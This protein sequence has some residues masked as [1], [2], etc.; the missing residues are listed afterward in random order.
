MVLQH[1][2]QRPRRVVV[3]GPALDAD[4]LGHRDL[5]VVDH[6]R[7]PEPVEDRVGE[8]QRQQVLH[9]LL[10]E[11]VVDPEDLLFRK[12]LADRVVDRA[13]RLEVLAD[14]LLEHDAGLLAD[15][16]ELGEVP[17][18]RAVEV[19][20]GREVERAH[21][22]G[23][24]VELG[25]EVGPAVV[26]GPVH[27]HVVEVVEEGGER[28]VVEVVG[29]HEA[30]QRVLR[31]GAERLHRE[32]RA[33]GADDP[34]GRRDLAVLVAVVQ[35]R[36]QLA[37]GEVA[38]RAEHD[39]VEGGDGNDGGQGLLPV[40]CGGVA[41]RRRAARAA[42]PITPRGL[43]LCNCFAKVRAKGGRGACGTVKHVA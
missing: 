14:R 20:R 31:A 25:H 43:G 42:G 32:F 7:R 6:V 1:V 17:A 24:L 29:R 4:G 41:V 27:R 19:G 16:A 9:R 34:G 37:G 12:H 36:Q 13:R 35:G 18:D 38:G 26:A 8:A 40:R 21:L 3:A 23:P 39:V 22:V 5:D 11:V 28:R 30:L 15:E 2:A 33:R 10:A